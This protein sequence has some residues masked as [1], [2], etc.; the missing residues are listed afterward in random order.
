MASLA[1]SN[2]LHD[3]VRF[4]VTVVGVVFAV[5]LVAVQIGL[6]IGFSTTTSNVI[7]HSQADLWIAS[8]NVDHLEVGVPMAE[9]KLYQALSTPGVLSAQKHIV[10]FVDW[11]CPNG[12]IQL[13]NQ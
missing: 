6:F 11:R 5:V 12:A 1:V 7:D 4:A 2:L 3:K 10:Q 13:M 8:Q 9:S